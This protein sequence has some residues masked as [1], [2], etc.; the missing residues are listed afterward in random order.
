MP[1][2]GLGDDARAM[3]ALVGPDGQVT[4]LDEDHVILEEARMRNG[5]ASLPLTFVEGDVQRL[6]IGDATFTHCRSERCSSMFPT[7]TLPCAN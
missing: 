6:D 3:A 5:D 4:G 7:S 1:A 2:V